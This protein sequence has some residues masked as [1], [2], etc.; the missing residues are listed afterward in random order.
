MISKL[1]AAKNGLDAAET[2][3]SLARSRVSISSISGSSESWTERPSAYPRNFRQKLRRNSSLRRGKD[4]VL[5]AVE[6][7]EA[8]AVLQLGSR[9]DRTATQVFLSQPADGIVRF[10]G[11]AEGIDAVVARGARGDAPVLLDELTDGQAVGGGL[12]VGELGDVLRRPGQLLAE[13]AL[14]QPVAT[15]DRAGARCPRLL[16]QNRAQG[17]HAAATMGLDPIDPT[18]LRTLDP[19]YPVMLRQRLVQEGMVALDELRAPSGRCGTNR[20][21]TGSPPRGDRDGPW[22][23]SG[24]GARSSRRGCRSRG[25]PA[26]G[27]RT[28]WPGRG[29]G[30]LAPAVGPG[31]PAHPGHG[32][33]PR[34]R[35]GS[36]TSSG[37]EA[38]RK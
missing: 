9:I 37:I 29:P 34:R 3:K 12:V 4:V 16:R 35:P 15:Q 2:R 23:T 32:A 25:S 6:P 7:V 33:G 28:R 8:G 14:E 17:E 20:R 13:Q 30:R 18:P 31:R 38:Q 22:R 27:R 24:S 19:G 11:E 26:T 36:S 10:Q 1:L 5:E 21:R